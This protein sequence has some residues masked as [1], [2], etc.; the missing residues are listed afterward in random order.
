METEVPYI[1]DIASLPPT[2]DALLEG[3]Q[4]ALPE[5]VPAPDERV[6]RYMRELSFLSR[7]FF[8]QADE[9]LEND[10]RACARALA[11]YLLDGKDKRD[12]IIGY[13]DALQTSILRHVRLS[14]NVTGKIARFLDAVT[15]EFWSAYSDQFRLKVRQQQRETL[16]QELRLAK[17]IQAR[18]LPKRVPPVPGFDIE[19]RLIPA[20]EVGGDYWSCKYYEQDGIVTVK[21][22]DIAGHGIAAA[23]LVSAVKFIS[24]GWYRG[25]DS[26]ADVIENTNRVL[27]KETPADI[28]VTMFY[29]WLRPEE[30]TIDIVNAGHHPILFCRSENIQ[31]IPPTGPVLGLIQSQFK[32]ERYQLETGDVI[33][34]CSDGV[35]EARRQEPFGTERLKEVLRRHRDLSAGEQCDAVIHAVTRFAGQPQDDISMIAI[36]VLDPPSR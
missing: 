8:A 33:F 23:M 29:G 32:E 31:E 15:D 36:R 34:C 20:S 16:T 22:A 11:M 7:D 3:W 14:P 28:L 2:R 30:R 5:S 18:L 10:I 12:W 25:A 4:A 19:G 13:R 27:V 35:I 9:F 1:P 17:E 21:L 6:Y 26:A 24:G